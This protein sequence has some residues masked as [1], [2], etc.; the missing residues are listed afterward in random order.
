V[1]TERVVGKLI[2]ALYEPGPDGVEVDVTDK[3]QEISIFLA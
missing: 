2:Q 1:P 3:F